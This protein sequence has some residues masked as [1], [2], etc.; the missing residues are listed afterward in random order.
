MMTLT[1]TKQPAHKLNNL[2]TWLMTKTSNLEEIGNAVESMGNKK[3]PGE[4]GITG[5][6]YKSTFKIFPSL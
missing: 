2:W 3:A 4:D 6:I 1:T 5:E